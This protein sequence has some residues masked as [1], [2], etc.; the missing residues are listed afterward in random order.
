MRKILEQCPSCGRDLEVNRLSC[1]HCETVIQGRFVPCRFCK[2]SPESLAFVE[3]FVK[4]RGN[5][6]E[7]E[8]ELGISYPTARGKLNAVIEELGFQ[9]ET[10]EEDESAVR[11]REILDRLNRGEMKASEAAEL[12]SELALSKTK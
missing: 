3:L 11:R 4:N 7:V 10:V 1:T 9:V 5:I 2:L 12:L 8:R 6:K